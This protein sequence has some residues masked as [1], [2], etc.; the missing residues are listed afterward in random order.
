MITR[1]YAMYQRSRKMLII[2]IA[3]FLALTIV[4]GVMSAI[5]SR[6]TSGRNSYS[7]ARISAFKMELT[8]F[9]LMKFGYL[10]PFGRSLRCVLLSGLL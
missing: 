2:F 8:T 6:H 10:A 9:S 7:P 4:G 3:L 5:T 1:L